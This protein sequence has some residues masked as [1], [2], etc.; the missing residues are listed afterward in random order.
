MAPRKSSLKVANA[1]KRPGKRN[2]TSR[3]TSPKSRP[4]PPADRRLPVVGIGAS[5]GGLHALQDFFG[6]IP[7]DSGAAFIVVQHLDPTR[8]SEMATLLG[9]R[10]TLKVVLAEEGMRL[11]PNVVYTIPPDR[12]LLVENEAIKLTLPAEPRGLRLPIDALF[13]S[14]AAGAAECAVG[15][16]LS[17]NGADG[18]LGLR[19][20]KAHGG[21]SI[22]QDPATAEYDAMPRNAIATGVVDSI[23][24]PARMIEAISAFLNHDYVKRPVARDNGSVPEFVHN[25]LAL[26]HARRNVDFSGYK[27]GT[28]VRRIE[29]RM[30]LRQLNRGPDYLR[31]L[32]ENPDE[33]NQL[34]NDLLIQVTRFFR[35]PESWKALEREVLI[36]LVGDADKDTPIR[37]WVPGCASGE[38]A[39]SLAMLLLELVEKSQKHIPI[40]IFASDLDRGSLNQARAGSYPESIAVDV[41]AERLN[42]FFLHT[43]HRYV[44]SQALRDTVIF[45]HHNLLVDPP[46]GRLDL[47]SCRNV[48]IYLEG[49]M[50]RRAFDLFHFALTPGRYLFLGNSETVGSQTDLFRPISKRSHIYRRLGGVRNDRVRI[51]MGGITRAMAT[52]AAAIVPPASRDNMLLAQAR[53]HVLSRYATASAVINRN[54]EILALFGRTDHYLTQPSGPLTAEI[55]S[56][57]GDGMRGKLRTAVQAAIRKNSHVTVGGAKH[58]R[59]EKQVSVAISVD[60]MLGPAE[61]DGLLVVVFRDEETGPPS[62]ARAKKE[63]EESVV[64]QL[65]YELKSARDELQTSTEQLE[66]SNEELRATNEEVLSMNEELQSTNEE[67]ETSKEEMQ[68]INEELNAVNSQLEGKIQEL[69]QL[70]DDVTNLQTSTDL[71]TLFLDRQFKIRRY[72]SGVTR[73]FRLIPADLGRPIEDIV[74]QVPDKGLLDDARDVLERLLP[75]EKEVPTATGGF[76]RRVLPYR[77]EDNRIE[78]VVVTYTDLS[79]R[80]RAD[81]LARES[82]DFAEAIVETLREPLLVLDEQLVVISAN[83]AYYRVFQAKPEAVIGKRI[84]EVGNREWSIPVLRRA[85]EKML[86]QQEQVNNLELRRH[87]A[88]VGERVVCVNARP[89]EMAGQQVI[90]LALEDITPRIEAERTRNQVLRQLVSAE[91][92]ERHRLA[93]ELHDET[94]Q[95]VTAFLLGLTALRESYL[96]QPESR[97]LIDDLRGRAEELARHLHGIALQLRPTAL[98]EH[99][100]ERALTGY[101]EDIALRHRLEIDFQAGKNFGRLPSHIETVLYRVTQEA[102]TNV[103][104]HSKSRKVSVVT[105]RQDREVSLIIE[106]DGAGFDPEKA[107]GDGN[108]S[109]LGLRGMRE[110]VMLAAGTLT[111]ESHPGSGTSLFVRIPLRH[112]NDDDASD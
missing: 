88:G 84:Y 18:S 5:A 9:R 68:S 20:I 41:S 36:R 27:K 47:I 104:R 110:R 29:R 30:S 25:V 91:E 48:L 19:T 100:L 58:R 15:V 55:L 13:H 53:D 16:V 1:R 23:L 81:R 108:K 92:Q 2:K 56:W 11:E 75:V 42:R 65:E 109:H 71:P 80:I 77:T 28:L 31:L 74:R 96:D 111:I 49:V 34:F 66:S 46:F 97:V 45:S 106:D 85:L 44:V 21:M 3:K 87:F 107:L 54:M 82:R 101:L 12:Y 86:P 50:H 22:A 83:A 99:G 10:T 26:L 94:G 70:N 90:L 43:E 93:L 64:R 52:P 37:V 62:K 38:E 24:P 17:G 33:V 95:H 69:Q 89:L 8:V 98:D 112:G 105:S 32:R 61:T 78:G 14:L 103:L 7:P 40:Q 72:T 59:G 73:L 76:L 6:T 4:A 57:V 35:E 63:P 67:L 79:D 102:I 51:S 60:P 39:Y